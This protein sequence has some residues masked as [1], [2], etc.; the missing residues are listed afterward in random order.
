MDILA[1]VDEDWYGFDDEVEC[2]A[3]KL[4]YDFVSTH[5]LAL[6]WIMYQALVQIMVAMDGTGRCPEN[7]DIL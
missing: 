2:R 4:F 6:N 5:L 1:N 3:H 7:E